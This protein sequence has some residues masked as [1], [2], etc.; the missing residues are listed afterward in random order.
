MRQFIA[1]RGM[2]NKTLKTLAASFFGDLRPRRHTP[3]SRI[4]RPDRNRAAFATRCAFRM[5]VERPH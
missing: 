2:L 1:Y 5:A 3:L 4:A